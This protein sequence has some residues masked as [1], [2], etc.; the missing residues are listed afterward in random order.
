MV[1]PAVSRFWV[2]WQRHTDPR[3]ILEDDV[4]E[5]ADAAIAWGRARSEVILI[6]LGNRGDTCFSAGVR[7]P[8][9]NSAVEQV[10]HWP[11]AGRPPDG[12]WAPPRRPDRTAIRSIRIS[13]ASGELDAAEAKAWAELRLHV[14]GYDLDPETVRDLVVVTELA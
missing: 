6:R 2:S 8:A 5:G 13:V 14:Y 12:W 7:H 4:I 9:D 1:D 11:P 3:G 10:P